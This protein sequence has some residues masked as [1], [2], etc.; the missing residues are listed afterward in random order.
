MLFRQLFDPTTSTYT[1]LLADDTTK[2]AVLI[3][4]VREQV[5]RDATLVEQLGLRLVATVE[6]H[7][8]ADHV[9]G[10][11]AL[12]KRFG[13][14]IVY[15]A[16]AGVDGAR[17]VGEGAVVPFG[18]RSLHVRLTPGHTSGCATYVLDDGSKA[19]TGDALLVQGTG[20]TDFQQGDARQLFRSVW[21]QILTLPD[22]TELY[23]AH[24][25]KGR[26]VTTVAEEKAFN[27]RLGAGKTED[28]FVA[29]MDQLD[30]A[31]PRFIDEALPANQRLGRDAD[32]T[33]EASP[34]A[35][36]PFADMPRGPTGARHVTP[37]WVDQ[38]A[39]EVRLIDVRQPEEFTG[40]LGYI[41]GSELVPLDR[42][43][44][45][46]SSWP[47]DVPIVTI[48]RSSGRSDRA[49]LALESHGFRQVASMVG[50][51]MAWDH[52]ALSNGAHA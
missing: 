11:W 43:M 39:A 4:P 1:Y 41:D 25:Y 40:P 18:R 44:A 28:D 19:F 47:K 48:C 36:D 24:D 15:P 12:H 46:A 8:H 16:S 35:V 27:P 7:V 38:H 23:P 21:D 10:A 34:A 26:T 29:I 49:A 22:D 37:V 6:T 51:M 30:L 5:E 3:D 14:D 17:T 31:Y 45:E 33:A 52:S 2:E 50:G 9:T 32:E 20:R 42:L 13:S